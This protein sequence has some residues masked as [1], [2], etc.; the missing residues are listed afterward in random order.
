MVL[1]FA[2]VLL[3]LSGSLPPGLISLSV[4]QTA[5]LRGFWAA[6]VLALGAAFAEFFQALGAVIFSDWFLMHPAAARVFQV[7]AI[8][9]FL[10]LAVYL[11]FFAKTPRMPA[12]EAPV[13]PLRQFGR[14][15]AISFFNLL[16][17]PYWVIYTGWLRVNGWWTDGLL[18]T[19]LFATGVVAGTVAALA[20]YAWLALEMTRRSDLVARVVNRFVALVFLGLGLKLVW[21]LL[22]ISM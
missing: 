1:F 17:I 19:L 6:M 13:A 11:W 21:E 10:G 22:K 16:A 4:A 15:V 18:H 20:L 12:G 3:S 2:G 8:P 7:V 5:I 14:G 9:V